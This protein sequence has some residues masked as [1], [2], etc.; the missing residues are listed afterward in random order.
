M[1]KQKVLGVC[2]SVL[3]FIFSYHT[4]ANPFPPTWSGG[5]GPAVHY[6]PVTWPTEPVNPVNCGTSCGQWKPYTRFQQNM[7]DPRTQDPSTGGTSPQA[8]VNVT[9]SCADATLPSIYYYLHQGATAADDVLMFRWR[10]E[11][12]PNNYATGPSPGSYGA[13]NPWS[14]ALWTV[15]FDIDG[16]GYRSL[17][18]HLDGSTGSPSAAI[19]RMVGIWSNTTSQSLD[20]LTDPNVHALGHNSTGFVG[21]TGKIMNFHSTG[22]P[23]EMWPNGSSETVW[24]YGTTR[25]RTVTQS[26]CT[27]YFIDYQIPIALLDAS[28]IGGPKITRT[29][30]IS[31][32]FCTANG[33][34]N[35]FQKDCA[36]NKP[37]TADPTKP[38][39]FGDYLSFNQTISY[40]QPIISSVSAIAPTSCP[41]SYTLKT[42]VQDTLAVQSGVV[43]PSVQNVDFFYWVDQ[44]GD[45]TANEVGGAWTKIATTAT[46]E[47]GTLNKW[48]TTWNASS[49]PKGKY[50]IGTQALDDNTK[51]DTGMTATGINNRTFSYLTGDNS[52][53]MYIGSAW[54]SGQQSAFPTHSPAQTPSSSENWYGNPDVTGLSIAIVGTAINTCGVAPTIALT[55]NKSSVVAGGTL[56]YIITLTNPSSNSSA[57]TVSQ[58]T[59]TLPSGFAYQT[60]TTVGTGGLGSSNPSISGQ[61]LTWAYGSPVSLAPGASATLVLGV[62]ATNIAGNYNA[63]AASIT[64]FGTIQSSPVAIAV[65]AARLSFTI[66]PNAY[67]IAA[68]GSTQLTFTLNYANAS[69]VTVTG[70]TITGSLPSGSTYVSCSGGS[71]CSNTSGSLSWTL[72]TLAGGASGSATLVLT[73]PSTWSTSSL[74]QSATLTATAPDASSVIKTATS[75]VAVTGY[76]AVT[77][78]GFTI[79]KSANAIQI[80]PAGTVTYTIA[81]AN[82]GGTAASNVVITDSL[83]A[84]MSYLSSTGSGVPSGNTV[85]WTIATVAAGASGSVTVTA[86][87]ATPFTAG[88]P[89]SNSASI[90]WTGGALVTSA[91]VAVGITGLAC[92]TYYFRSTM[93]NVGFDGTQKLAT[94]SPAPVSGDTGSSVTVTAPTGSTFL[95]ALR[96]YQ[97]PATAAD[98][99]FDGNITTNIYIDRANGQGLNIRS[100]VYDYNSITGAKTQLAQNTQLFNG[101]TKGLLSF[102]VTPS[103][104]LAKD[105]RLLWVYEVR[106]NH[107]SQTVQ[108]QIQYAGT[109]TNTISGGS[110]FANSNATYC[111][112]PPASLSTRVTVDQAS[113]AA[114][115]TPTLKYTI[116]YSNTGSVSATNASL[117]NTLPS[118][119]TGCEFSLNNS[120]WSAC[121]GGNAHTFSLG[122]VAGGSSG[123][124]RYVR[125]IV[126]SGTVG[127]E[128][129]TNNVSLSS[130]QT[131]TVTA[132]AITQVA[133]SGGG[134]GVANLTMNLTANKTTAQPGDNVVYTL[135]VANVGDTSATSVVVTNALPV[136]SYFTYASCTGSCVNS[137]N[138]LTWSLGT[139]AAGASQTYTYTM[140]V[141]SSGLSSGV[142]VISDD[143]S[144]A[145]AAS[146]S[147]TSNSVSL[148]LNGNPTLSAVMTATPNTGLLVGNTI[149]Y[150]ITLQ[151]TGNAAA[152][153]IQSPCKIPATQ[154]RH[155]W[156]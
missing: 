32:L 151:N 19:D 69:T 40:S 62:T 95:E 31:M 75:T 121:S 84:G 21:P 13:S 7:N 45:G 39:P 90:N 26:S 15:L 17:A 44:N 139:L 153:P 66:T 89:T 114:A 46:L 100:T 138:T 77:P 61:V 125:G 93:A 152:T 55:A 136:A 122:T 14:S 107:A 96:F 56:S 113:I 140:S 127:G 132:T 47:T 74:T 148:T 142:T 81:Y 24:D 146:V 11:S 63:T 59:E 99:P 129:F 65:D 68:N 147:A 131:S 3:A 88:N 82:Y 33:S 37:W 28:G 36:I 105:H 154:R 135:T 58:I 30:P 70:A 108:V 73:V 126:P 87:A 156:W 72:G 57:I 71:A 79:T 29:T 49:L 115:A 9:S 5:T 106:S 85:T 51:L 111:I 8:Y 117:V 50:L 128:T 2:V 52:N 64:S 41:G 149:T 98:V 67:S 134:G 119:F 155:R 116:N 18:A 145:G 78:A 83:P 120:T 80:A 144:A 133:S 38:A 23:D 102:T 103:G 1:I 16:S 86:T 4:F 12:A 141:G 54:K 143:A 92:S 42:T 43:V 53:E 22:S 34:N 27:E 124:P 112:T 104:T 76:T 97:D 118:G 110:T 123:T 20:Y 94:S 25:A 101:S 91:S 6:S 10:V 60:G 109:V 130:D 137:S 150:S 35:P 48:T